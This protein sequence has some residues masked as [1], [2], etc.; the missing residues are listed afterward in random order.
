MEEV[1]V[2]YERLVDIAE[3]HHGLNAGVFDDV[4]ILVAKYVHEYLSFYIL[5]LSEDVSDDSVSC[6]IHIL[7][8]LR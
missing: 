6:G 7:S 8:F 1:Q 3:E 2:Q 5:I 4:R